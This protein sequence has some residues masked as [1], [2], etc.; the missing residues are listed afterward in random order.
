V[1]VEKD[2]NIT[3]E[4]SPIVSTARH[5]A[6]IA[7]NEFR[8]IARVNKRDFPAETGQKSFQQTAIYGMLKT[9]E[10]KDRPAWQQVYLTFANP[11]EF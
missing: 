1:F 7:C 2:L 8:S 9:S 10:K 5:N 6:I 11:Q 4:I 3:T